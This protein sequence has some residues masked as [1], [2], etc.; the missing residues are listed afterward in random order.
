MVVI[1]RIDGKS[2]ALPLITPEVLQNFLEQAKTMGETRLGQVGSS[3]GYVAVLKIMILDPMIRI[4]NFNLQPEYRKPFHHSKTAI[5][6]LAMNLSGVMRL[7]QTGIKQILI[8]Y[9]ADIDR[10]N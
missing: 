10:G 7:C 3:M 1:T 5:G 9:K 4:P 8:E 6:Y 2:I